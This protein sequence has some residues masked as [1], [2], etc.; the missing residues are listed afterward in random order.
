MGRCMDSGA[1]ARRAASAGYRKNAAVVMIGPGSPP[2][3]DHRHPGA[4]RG[5]S[6]FLRPQPLPVTDTTNR[7]PDCD[8]TIVAMRTTHAREEERPAEGEGTAGPP[9]HATWP[10]RASGTGVPVSRGQR[11]TA[12]G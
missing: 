3:G 2:E 10:E 8:H 5:P 9:R 12:A 6:C 7:A 1:S 11:E 4:R